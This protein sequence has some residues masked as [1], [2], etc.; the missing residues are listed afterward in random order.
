MFDT[1]VTKLKFGSGV[2]MD[3]LDTVAG[4]LLK[5]DVVGTTNENGQW[6]SN[7]KYEW[8]DGRNEMNEVVRSN[9]NTSE[10]FRLCQEEVRRLHPHLDVYPLYVIV[11]MD[12]TEMGKFCKTCSFVLSTCVFLTSSYIFF[13]VSK[14][15]TNSTLRN[16]W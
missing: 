6:E 11:S 4:L 9:C 1:D 3:I 5:N 10:S 14:K 13:F 2:Y 12:K 7:F 16:S 15:V 8:E